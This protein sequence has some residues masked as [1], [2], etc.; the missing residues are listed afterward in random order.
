MKKYIIILI[1]LLLVV[2]CNKS[3]NN[4]ENNNKPKPN[5]EMVVINLFHWS[6]C[7]HCKEEINWLKELEKR[8]DYIKVNY[9]EVTEYEDL[10]A[11]VR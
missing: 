2:G 11:K 1:M 8:E 10:N 5:Q 4:E 6:Q 9:Y 3:K 7:S